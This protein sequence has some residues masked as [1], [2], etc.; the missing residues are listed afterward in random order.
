MGPRA[1]PAEYRRGNDRR[2]AGER[3]RLWLC[4]VCAKLDLQKQAVWGWAK[5]FCTKCAKDKGY[6]IPQK[7]KTRSHHKKKAKKEKMV[8]KNKTTN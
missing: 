1:I 8:E 3:N 5:G 2:T 6:T 4:P 7:Q